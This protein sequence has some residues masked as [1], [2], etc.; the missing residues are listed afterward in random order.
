MI[1][2]CEPHRYTRVRDLFAEFSA[3]FGDADAVIVTP[4][5]SAG[6][7]PIVAADSRSLARA[8]RVAGR[9]AAEVLD[10]D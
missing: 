6:E 10:G 4:L 9:L 1:A 5:Y 8:L 2:V 7:A 3:C